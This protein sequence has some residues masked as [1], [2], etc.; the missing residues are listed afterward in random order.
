MIV[1]DG[2]SALSD[3]RLDRLN[4]R[5]DAIAKNTRVRGARHVYFVQSAASL[6][7]ALHQRLAEVLDATEA[8]PADASL[9][10]VPRL[11]TMSPWSS[12]ATDILHHVGI[13]VS[14][15]ER[16]TAFLIDKLPD[17]GDPAFAAIAEALHDPM[18][19][20]VLRSLADA[21]RI[22]VTGDAGAL[23]SVALDGDARAALQKANVELG[24]AL[25]P[26]EV[27][28]LADNY[29]K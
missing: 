23:G 20:S 26:D 2:R 25:A 15:V 18:T 14:R 7:P 10:V 3:F 9:W 11:G 21:P 27:Q 17:A 29:A 8:P 4:Q 13:A 22:F 19:Q 12:K 1:L 5:I 24:L 6:P 28:Y 16:G